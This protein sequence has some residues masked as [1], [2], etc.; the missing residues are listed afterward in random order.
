MI[1]TEAAEYLGT[2]P[3]KIINELSKKSPE[4]TWTANS[5]MP[6]ELVQIIEAKAQEYQRETAPQ[7]EGKLT[8]SEAANLVQESI[9]YAILEAIESYQLSAL[10]YSGQVSAAREIQAYEQ[11][12]SSVWESYFNSQTALAKG[13]IEKARKQAEAFL[14]A[15]QAKQA[16]RVRFAQQTASIQASIESLPKLH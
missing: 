3:K 7:V 11:G 1:I 14:P 12:K 9:E 8:V 10:N 2:T 15:A 6:E 5:E 13:Q 16:G 4:I